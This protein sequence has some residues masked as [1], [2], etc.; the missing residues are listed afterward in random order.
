[1]M[2]G[3]TNPKLLLFLMVSP[4]CAQWILSPRGAGPIRYGLSV[5]LV[6]Q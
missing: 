3:S 2:I 4:S 5:N 6:P 1:M